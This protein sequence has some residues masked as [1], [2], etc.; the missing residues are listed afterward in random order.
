VVATVSFTDKKL[1]VTHGDKWAAWHEFVE[2]A[3]LKDIVDKAKAKYETAAEYN[4]KSK[5]KG[6]EPGNWS[7]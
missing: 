7:K 3:A 5:G 1:Q 4:G 6:K 2:D